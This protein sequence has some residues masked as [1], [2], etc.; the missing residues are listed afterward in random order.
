MNTKIKE[1]II[2]THQPNYIPWL[3]YFYKIYQSDVF[4]FLDDVQFIKKGLINYT[5]IKTSNGSFRLKY[6]VVETRGDKIN[7]VS[8]KDELNWK[9]NH[10]Q[11]IEYNYRKAGYFSTVFNDYKGLV[12]KE[13]VS[14]ADLN[15]ALVRF[16]VDKL[17]IKTSFLNSSELNIT[18]VKE[19]RII[20]ICKVLGGSIY[21]S[22][23]GARA[24]QK[25]ENFNFSGIELRY[26]VFKPF[27]YT[28]L[29]ADFQS[30]VSALDFFMNCG[31]DWDQ[32]LNFQK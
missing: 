32:V 20:D 24:Y 8:S 14:I 19:D 28:Q 7:E 23:N 25:E 2:A 9:E 18:S 5:Y 11:I 6:P 13:Y 31:Y 3:G 10:L 22:G 29:W 17:G 15:I 4:V 16:F 26:S 12:E 1:K 21:Y 27:R 30:D